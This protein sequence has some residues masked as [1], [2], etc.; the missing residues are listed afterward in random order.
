MWPHPSFIVQG[1]VVVHRTR[2]YFSAAYCWW[3]GAWREGG[4]ER[5]RERAELS[6][7]FNKEVSKEETKEESHF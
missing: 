3:L 1:R 7:S 5:G 4:R 2:V 6:S